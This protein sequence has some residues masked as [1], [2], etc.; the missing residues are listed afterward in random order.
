MVAANEKNKQKKQK[1]KKSLM[2]LKKKTIA[3]LYMFQW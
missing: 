3:N 2:H 1:Q